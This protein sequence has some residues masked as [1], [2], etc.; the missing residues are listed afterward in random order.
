M[1]LVKAIVTTRMLALVVALV[2]GAAILVAC[3][4]DTSPPSVP[5]GLT[6]TAASS[7]TVNLGWTASTDN[8][9][10]TGYKIFRNGQQIATSTKLTY[11]DTQLAALDDLHL[12]RQCVRR[13]EQQ[14][15][16]VD[17]RQRHDTS[18]ARHQLATVCGR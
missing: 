13:V 18:G 12:R 10:V 9:G 6:A 4:P 16:A 15:C 17:D 11:K 3:T 2:V 5:T 1:G 8:I 7:T 14:L